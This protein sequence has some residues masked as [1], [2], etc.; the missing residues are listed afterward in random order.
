MGQDVGKQL[1]NIKDSLLRGGG[2][3]SGGRVGAQLCVGV[4]EAALGGELGRGPGGRHE[5]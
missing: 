2:I 5:R 1:G 4:L 3:Q